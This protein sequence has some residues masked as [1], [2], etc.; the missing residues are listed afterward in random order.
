[1]AA[2]A[3]TDP[4][5]LGAIVAMAGAA[6]AGWLV[7][8]AARRLLHHM[9]HVEP[10]RVEVTR[11]EV[12]CPRLPRG[13]HGLTICQLSDLHIAAAPRNAAEIEAAIR[14]VRADLFVLTGDMIHPAS[15][16]APF[17][18]WWDRLEGAASPAVAVLG[19]AEH[20]PWV[21]AEPLRKG[22]A[23]RGVPLLVN[24]VFRF[25]Y[26]GDALQIVGVDDPHTHRAD[27]ARAYAQADP[28]CWTLLLCHSPDGLAALAGRR[29][30]LVLAGHTHG[31]Q[32]RLPL[33]GALRDNLS[34]VHGLVA[35]WYA[36]PDLE[37]RSRGGLTGGRLYVSRGLGGG[38]IPLRLKCRP[39]VAVFT[40]LRDER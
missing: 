27:F 8:R 31:G 19:N 12:L 6:A 25:A 1:L 11:H 40:L 7:T 4:W 13:L 23:Q 28:A 15:G 14:G 34:R 39:E 18:A 10:K 37:R 38:S 30:D 22:L 16:A 21:D 24:E 2:V 36:G 35:G 17:L 33:L 9:K 32:V 3:L 5:L 26:G 20:K 29:A